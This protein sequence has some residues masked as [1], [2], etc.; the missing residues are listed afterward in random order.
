MKSNRVLFCQSRCRPDCLPADFTR[1]KRG[2]N[3]RRRKKKLSKIENL[4]IRQNSFKSTLALSPPLSAHSPPRSTLRPST[5][6][7][8]PRAVSSSRRIAPHSIPGQNRITMSRQSGAFE[9]GDQSVASLL[10]TAQIRRKLKNAEVGKSVM[11][12]PGGK[13]PV[14]MK[15]REQILSVVRLKKELDALGAGGSVKK[16][17]AKVEKKVKEVPKEE[18]DSSSLSSTSAPES[19]TTTATRAAIKKS[20]V[21]SVGQ[22]FGKKPT[23]PL[24]VPKV[25]K[26]KNWR[27]SRLPTVLLP[28]N[29]S[30]TSPSLDELC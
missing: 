12:N 15:T 16:A 26:K 8:P 4:P 1:A 10:K 3:A 6:T 7:R 17:K 9:R 11:A 13:G 21:D 24:K 18:E 30:C 28:N 2:E 25:A 27:K 29:L 5:R 23:A 19:K 22:S 20:I 14:Q